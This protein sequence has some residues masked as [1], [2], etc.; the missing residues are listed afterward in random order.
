MAAAGKAAL[1]AGEIARPRGFRDSQYR[2]PG[3]NRLYQPAGKVGASL[4][5]FFYKGDASYQDYERFKQQFGKDAAVFKSVFHN[6]PGDFD[7]TEYDTVWTCAA[8]PVHQRNIHMIRVDLFARARKGHYSLVGEIINR[9]RR[10]SVKETKE[11]LEKANALTELEDVEKPLIFVFCTGDFYKN[12]RAFM[13]KSRM[14]WCEDG[15]LPG[16]LD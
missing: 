2:T 8:S 9:K 10:F 12:T 5:S 11:F 3:R 15:R 4:D 7:F 16:D 1:S 6:L 14:A 13:E